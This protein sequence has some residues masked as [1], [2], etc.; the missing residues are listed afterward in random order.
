L[1]AAK[2]LAALY[3]FLVSIAL[4]GA[5]F[6]TFGHGFSEWLIA[7][8][9]N[10]F[11]GLFVGILSTSIVQSSSATTSMVV[12]LVA[13][14]SLTIGNAVPIV[15]GANI[16]TTVTNTLV[17]L[18]HV[19]RREE[20]RRAMSGALVHDF[21]NVLTVGLLL[22]VELV[23][24]LVWGRGILQTLATGLSRALTGTGGV[25]YDSPLKLLV[26]P[27]AEAVSGL[28][29]GLPDVA[30]GFLILL[31]ALGL[32]FATLL[33]MTRIMRR[34]IRGRIE[35]ALDRA[36]GGSALVGISVGLVL[37]ALVQSSSC[38]TSILVPLAG[39]GVL[40]VEQIYPITLGANVGT[41]VTA[42]LAALATI[43]ASAAGGAGIEGNEGLTIALVH[44]LFNVCGI[45][46][47]YPVPWVR[48]LPVRMS[49]GIARRSVRSRRF[50]VLYVVGTFFV[51]PGL[52][53]FVNGLF[54]GS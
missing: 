13:E 15:M 43:G 29:S 6:K 48:A 31:V 54:T 4:L 39:A 18:G 53:I 12:S 32:L 33:L 5:A 1:E 51:V 49:K 24:G 14:G 7:S 8:T 30:K 20:F 19:T 52:L 17:S 16:G 34:A 25:K 50:A 9:T 40:T 44:L 22:P 41:T 21:F 11:V 27:L 38:V 42:I 45:G 35:G 23:T 37:T 3:V 47:I 2:F 28:F 10:P 26:R 36:F 46:L